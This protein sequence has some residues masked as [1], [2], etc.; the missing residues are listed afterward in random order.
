MISSIL[1]VLS[2][3]LAAH[4]AWILVRNPKD[5]P[6]PRRNAYA[7]CVLVAATGATVWTWGWD[8]HMAS[9]TGTLGLI[10][11]VLGC[12]GA[13]FLGRQKSRD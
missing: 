9:I 3:A 8:T 4:G 2:I 1:A 12:L 6:T 5:W 7:A 11:T 13:S 10:L